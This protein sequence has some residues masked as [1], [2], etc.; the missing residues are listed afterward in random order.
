ME[1]LR[2]RFPHA[3]VLEFAPVGGEPSLADDLRRARAT[4]DPVELS[5]RFVDYVTGGP[6]DDAELAVLAA[7]H[8]DA[9]RAELSG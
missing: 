9:L 2:S 6:V 7:A 1:R 5:T 4:V 3:L 8:E